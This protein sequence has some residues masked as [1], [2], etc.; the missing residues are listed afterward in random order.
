MCPVIGVSLHR[1]RAFLYP[2]LH[3]VINR[4]RRASAWCWNFTTSGIARISSLHKD[5]LAAL[6]YLNMV[7]QC[8]RIASPEWSRHK[9][10]GRHRGPTLLSELSPAHRSIHKHRAHIYSSHPS[11]PQVRRS[12]SSIPLSHSHFR[13]FADPGSALAHNL[14]FHTHR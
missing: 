1:H 4:I 2:K 10:S 9:R 11:S 14:P 6:A 13:G 12:S 3:T 5:T 7:P 8:G